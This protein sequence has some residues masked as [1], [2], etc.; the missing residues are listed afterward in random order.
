MGFSATQDDRYKLLEMHV[1][2]D[3]PGYEDENGI[4]LPYVVTIDKASATI[5]SV[6]ATVPFKYAGV[7]YVIVIPAAFAG[8]AM[9][10]LAIIDTD[11][12]RAST[13]A[14]FTLFSFVVRL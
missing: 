2:L 13:F 4:A 9:A 7:R 5:L 12:T 14:F 8:I 11:A 3:L 6:E 1:D 10:K